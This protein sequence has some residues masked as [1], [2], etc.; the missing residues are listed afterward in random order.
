MFNPTDPPEV[1]ADPDDGTEERKEQPE[2]QG[3][4]PE[5]AANGEGEEGDGEDA[6]GDD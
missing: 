2:P 1:C 4:E 6:E 3:K 5:V